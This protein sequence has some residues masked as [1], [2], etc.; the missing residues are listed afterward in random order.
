MVKKKDINIFEKD[1]V[2]RKKENVVFI[3]PGR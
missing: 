2:R 1:V 3:P